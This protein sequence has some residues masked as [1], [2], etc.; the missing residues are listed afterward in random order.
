[1]TI[2]WDAEMKRRRFLDLLDHVERLVLERIEKEGPLVLKVAI[3]QTRQE[4]ESND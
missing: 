2:D 1:V 3:G 4:E